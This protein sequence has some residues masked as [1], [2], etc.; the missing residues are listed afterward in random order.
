[1][2][3]YRTDLPQLS[4]GL[5]LTD[6]GIETTLI[7][8][9]GLALP[10]FAAFDLLKSAAGRAALKR[11]FS[12]YTALAKRSGVGCVLESPTWRASPDW[13]E[14]LGYPP[15]T[16]REA[17]RQAVAL[18]HDTRDEYED[19]VTKVVISGCIGPRGDGYRPGFLMTPDEAQGY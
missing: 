9:D 10:H 12:T 4:G 2:A 15:E 3:R 19:A 14:K 1:M 11:Y 8:R 6:G 5:F 7:F 17:N 18:L 13:G 16:L